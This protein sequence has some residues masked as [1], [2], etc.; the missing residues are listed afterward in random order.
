MVETTTPIFNADKHFRTWAM[1]EVY[2]EPGV[3]IYVPNV[4]DMVI[5]WDTGFY[6]V[7]A[8][9]EVTGI[10]TLEL[11]TNPKVGNGVEEEDI[12]LGV[13]GSNQ[14]E[15]FRVYLDTSVT[16]HTL[17]CDSRLRN[18]GSDTN[19]IKIFKGTDITDS[20]E[21]ISAMFASDGT[22]IGENIPM[23]LVVIPVGENKAVKTPTVGYTL[24][25]LDDGEVVTVVEYG[26]VAKVTNI[27]KMLIKNTSFIRSTEANKRYIESIHLESPFLSEEDERLI[28][29]PINMPIDDIPLT[30]VITYSDGDPVKL[31]GNAGKFKLY[32]IDHFTAT[33]IGQKVP[34]VL[35]YIL[36]EDEVN[37]GASPGND[38]HI[39]EKYWGITTEYEEAYNV[40]LFAYPRW[41]DA[42][43]GYVLD[44]YLY[45]LD[46]KKA[47]NVTDMV[48]LTGN[49][50][51]L[52]PLTYNVKQNL[53]FAVEMNRVDSS[54]PKYRHVQAMSFTLKRPGTEYGDKW[55]SYLDPIEPYGN[56]LFATMLFIDANNY[57]VDITNGLTSKEVWLN[58]LYFATRPL[59][60]P[61]QEVMPPTPN[62]IILKTPLREYEFTINEWNSPL[63]ITGD[64]IVQGENITLEF[65]HRSY[66]NDLHLA[67]AALPVD[68][69]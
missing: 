11:W 26:D 61:E 60:N 13:S 62:I 43:S 67:V 40:K 9:N 36:N 54:Y 12:L 27:T 25:E 56:G 57:T 16:P 33:I 28:R 18:F 64:G 5:D 7:I 41:K 38:L 4:D 37:Y 15:S 48:S 19:H 58:H 51:A 52:N 66:E 29:F 59:Y 17:A 24:S 45:T 42:V 39:S 44:F 35:T 53:T 69:I 32:G 8:V 55:L 30:G 63:T 20:G 47:Y 2:K 68:I 34:L 14:S 1:S 21:V 46:R 49:S 10:S 22:F 3:G 6:R 50:P 23:E 65:I 31:P